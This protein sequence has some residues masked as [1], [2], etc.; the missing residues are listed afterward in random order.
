MKERMT[1]SLLFP[2]LAALIIAVYAG[3]LGVIFMVVYATP[4]GPMGV[5]VLGMVLL[6]GVPGAA[7][8]AQRYLE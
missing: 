6:I 8:I 2:L 7:A 5:I 3:G 1:M 4:M